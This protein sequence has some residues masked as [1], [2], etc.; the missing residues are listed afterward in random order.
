MHT[1]EIRQVFWAAK[2]GGTQVWDQRYLGLELEIKTTLV[3]YQTGT[4]IRVGTES[5]G[6]QISA[7]T[8]ILVG[9]WE[10]NYTRVR[11][12]RYLGQEMESGVHTHVRDQTC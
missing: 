3:W 1:F 6:T 12:D 10:W 8:R 7:Q 4:D 11:S 2:N 9:T 5:G